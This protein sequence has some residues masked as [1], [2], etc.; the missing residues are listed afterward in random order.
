M[1]Y[2]SLEQN[3][4]GLVIEQFSNNGVDIRFCRSKTPKK[5]KAL[6]LP[7]VMTFIE[8]TLPFWTAL[9]QIGLEVYGIEYRDHGASSARHKED[10]LKI[11]SDNF[12]TYLDDI[13]YFKNTYLKD[14]SIILI[15]SS[16]GGHLALRY[17]QDYDSGSARHTILIAPM[18]DLMSPIN[19]LPRSMIPLALKVLTW[20]KS[21][22]SIIPGL[23]YQT[24]DEIIAKEKNEKLRSILAANQ[25][26]ITTKLSLGWV[27]SALQSITELNQIHI[28][29]PVTVFLGKQEKVVN[30]AS[31]IKL[32]AQKAPKASF[33]FLNCPH[34][35]I[36]Y[37]LEDIIFE[38][39][40]LL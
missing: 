5:I 9:D 15:G 8:R 4:L 2:P 33:H 10:P 18:I 27:C 1:L 28:H 39:Q 38:I 29:T 36:D 7:G 3:S 37:H 12:E 11:H 20:V 21:T 34:R 32:I 35:I 13:N 40:K 22:Q 14:E 30:N 19:L 26:K 24:P 31:T 17:L 25:E 23:R 6:C 16:F